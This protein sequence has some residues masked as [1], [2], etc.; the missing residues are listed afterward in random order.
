MGLDCGNSLF[1]VTKDCVLLSPWMTPTWLDVYQGL[2]KICSLQWWNNEWFT[3]I[4]MP[5]ADTTNDIVLN[6]QTES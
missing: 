3:L 1:Q 5:M 4:P 2:V 6:F